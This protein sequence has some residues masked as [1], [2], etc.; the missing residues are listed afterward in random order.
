[1]SGGKGPV[2]EDRCIKT[3]GE[4]IDH[5]QVLISNMKQP[6]QKRRVYTDQLLEARKLRDA[7][8]RTSVME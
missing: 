1:M 8:I 7:L 5:L 4:L 2:F 3:A 6:S